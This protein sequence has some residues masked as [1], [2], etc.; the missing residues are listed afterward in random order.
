M[1]KDSG[2]KENCGPNDIVIDIDADDALIGRQ[3]LNV[4]N[5]IYQDDPNVWVLYTNY[6]IVTASGKPPS[7]G[8]CRTLK[9][10]PE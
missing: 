2:I 5:S 7:K 4:I 8:M 10:P 9:M 6:L 1:N 3:A